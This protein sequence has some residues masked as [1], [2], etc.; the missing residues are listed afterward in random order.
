MSPFLLKKVIDA[1]CEREVELCKNPRNGF[2]LIKTKNVNQAK[3]LVQL[4]KL[5]PTIT[6]AVTEHNFLNNSKGVIYTK[7]LFEISDEDTLTE[8][9]VFN[10]VEVKKIYKKLNEELIQTGLVI[11]TFSTSDPP[12]DI[13]I[14]YEHLQIRQYFPNPLRC[15]NCFK[16]GLQQNTALFPKNV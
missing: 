16:L 11:L 13:F 4:V 2:V 5:S 15:F 8:L 9:K 3:K 14:G 1:T 6:V 12:E 10:V 7:E